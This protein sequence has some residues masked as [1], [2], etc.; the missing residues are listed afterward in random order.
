MKTNSSSVHGGQL[1]PSKEKRQK[2]ILNQFQQ[3]IHYFDRWKRRYSGPGNFT[4]AV[5]VA[6]MVY[7]FKDHSLIIFLPNG[8]PCESIILDM[9]IIDAGR[10]DPLVNNPN[11]SIHFRHPK[12]STSSC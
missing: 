5:P 12:W 9:P 2:K 4:F 11:D 3:L 6:K 1:D 7:V 10:F 8:T